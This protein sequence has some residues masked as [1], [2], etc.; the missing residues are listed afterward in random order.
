[1]LAAGVFAALFAAV[2]AP[3]PSVAGGKKK[4]AHLEFRPT[5]ERALLEARV[6][7]VPVFVSRHKDF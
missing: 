5:Y 4:K 1:M 6:R 3:H 2:L 7:N